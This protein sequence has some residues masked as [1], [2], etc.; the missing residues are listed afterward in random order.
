MSIRGF[1]LGTNS[2]SLWPTL[3]G[4]RGLLVLGLILGLQTAS[5]NAF[6]LPGLA[7]VNFCE[8]KGETNYCQVRTRGR[9]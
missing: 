1:C 6:Y 4:L 2:W 9:K 7:P 5:S 3:P 8:V